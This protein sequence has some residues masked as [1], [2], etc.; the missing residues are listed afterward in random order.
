M[1]LPLFLIDGFVDKPFSG[2]PAAVCILDKEQSD[3]WMQHVAL[4][5]NQAETAFV[6]KRADG[7]L[8]VCAGLPRQ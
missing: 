5:M 1:N 2:N 7:G 8:G 4:E 3:S 6:H